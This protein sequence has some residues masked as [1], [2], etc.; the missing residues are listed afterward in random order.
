MKTLNQFRSGLVLSL[1]LVAGLLCAAPNASAQASETTQKV[2]IPFGFVANHQ[3]VP[4]GSYAVQMQSEHVLMLR[5]LATNRGQFVMVR[6]EPDKAIETRGRLIFTRDGNEAYLTQIRIPGSS[7][8][9]ETVVRHTA[10]RELA[11]VMPKASDTFE[12]AMR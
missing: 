8:H 6:P 3:Y 7:W 5:N 4:A 1:S 2:T 10:N 11:K 12:I 9:S